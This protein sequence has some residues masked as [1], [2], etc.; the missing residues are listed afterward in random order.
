MFRIACGP[1]LANNYGFMS[2]LAPAALPPPVRRA[3]PAKNLG[4]QIQQKLRERILH[5]HYPPGHH[6]GEQ[7]LCDELSASRIPVREA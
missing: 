5:W 4:L 6:L 3:A 2:P 1:R 7:E